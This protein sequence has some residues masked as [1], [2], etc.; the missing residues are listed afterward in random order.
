MDSNETIEYMHKSL[1]LKI[2]KKIMQKICTREL[3]ISKEDNNN[4]KVVVFFDLIEY[5]DNKDPGLDIPE[6]GDILLPLTISSVGNKN[7]ANWVDILIVDDIEINIEILKKMLENLEVQCNCCR[8]HRKYTIH[9]ASSGK[10]AL[11]MIL[12]QQKEKSGYRIVIMDCLMP[13]M[14]GW[15]TS[16]EINK[17]YSQ[18]KIRFLPYII[19]YSAFDSKEDLEKCIMSGMCCH[20]SKPCLKE[21]LCQAINDWINRN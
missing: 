2:S 12:K 5:N 21:E 7:T 8:V 14:D 13:S 4:V 3:I 17:L 6:E 16:V 1:K 15:E 18:G 9:E 19:A 20:I 10:N 11:E